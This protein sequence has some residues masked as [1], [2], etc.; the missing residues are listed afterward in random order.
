MS[1][2]GEFMRRAFKRHLIPRLTS[3]GFAGKSSNFERLTAT[4]QDLLSIQ[5]WKYGG[6]FILEF[7]RRERGPLLTAWGEIVPEE[8]LDVAYLPLSDR[9]RLQERPEVSR[10]IFSGFRFEGFGEDVDKYDALA[11]RLAGM[12][13]QVDAWLTGRERGPDVRPFGE[14]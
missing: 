5:Y 7:G 11:R 10:E 2:E 9:A 1:R 14:A 3:L 4:T 6:S 13:P 8:A 12:L